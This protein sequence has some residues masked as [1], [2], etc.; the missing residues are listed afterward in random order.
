MRSLKNVQNRRIINNI[1]SN[2]TAT[3]VYFDFP[4]LTHNHG[5]CI[6][7]LKPFSRSWQK[8]D[9]TINFVRIQGSII[10]GWLLF[11]SACLDCLIHLSLRWRRDGFSHQPTIL[12]TV[13]CVYVCVWR[14]L[15]FPPSIHKVL[16]INIVLL[17]TW[18]LSW[19]RNSARCVVNLFQPSFVTFGVTWHWS[20]F[21]RHV[22]FK[23]ASLF[24]WIRFSSNMS[25][26]LWKTRL[27]ARNMV[28]ALCYFHQ[29]PRKC[30]ADDTMIKPGK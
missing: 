22:A 3:L 19:R 11:I 2:L 5:K 13:K 20:L 7:A 6:N 24:V 30:K 21:T 17:R 10:G 1:P 15:S 25:V 23:F 4:L 8:A 12:I 29:F 18:Y 14:Q 16:R 9:Q 26:S 27:I 28:N